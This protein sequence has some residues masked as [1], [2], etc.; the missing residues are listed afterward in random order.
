M[1]E[2]VDSCADREL[3]HSGA[4]DAAGVRGIALVDALTDPWPGTGGTHAVATFIPGPVPES[5]QDVP[6][7]LAGA[8]VVP[9]EE[10]VRDEH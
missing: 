7:W 1:C 4:L 2:C 6:A 3:R 8:T 10:L 9:E 5:L